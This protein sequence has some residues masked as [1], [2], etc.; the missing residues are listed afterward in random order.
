MAEIESGGGKHQGGARRQRKKSTRIDMTAMVDVAFLL[1]TFFIL[2]TALASP[3]AML[4][5]QPEN[6]E[7]EVAQTKLMSILLGADD[8]ILYV[9]YENGLE[10]PTAN[11]T[12]FSAEGIRAAIQTHLNRRADRCPPKS[13]AEQIRASQ[14]WDPMF[15]IKPSKGSK[16]KNVIDILDEIKIN[17]ALKYALAPLTTEDS[18]LM[19]LHAMK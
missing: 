2:T 12:D 14:C 3:K 19:A 6:A 7:V 13:S 8:K 1:L 9:T 18:L 17:D 4:L 5:T 11:S 15:V 16:Y 10:A